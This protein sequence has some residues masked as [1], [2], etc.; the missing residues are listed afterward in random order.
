MQMALKVLNDE[1]QQPLNYHLQFLTTYL[2]AAELNGFL[3]SIGLDKTWETQSELDEQKAKIKE[4]QKEFA[5]KLQKSWNYN[6]VEKSFYNT[7]NG[8]LKDV[9]NYK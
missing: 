8:M 5:E 9:E 4:H 6:E 1:L 7:A 3:V 2:N